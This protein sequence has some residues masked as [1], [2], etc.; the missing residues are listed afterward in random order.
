MATIAGVIFKNTMQNVYPSTIR[1]RSI[2]ILYFVKFTKMQCLI[3][4]PP[5]LALDQFKDFFRNS[6]DG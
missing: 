2:A 6:I 4:F 1:H 5:L 3:F